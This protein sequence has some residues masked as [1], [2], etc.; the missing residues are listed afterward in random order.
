MTN[1]NQLLFDPPLTDDQPEKSVVAYK[2][3]NADLTCRDHQYAEGETYEHDGPAILCTSG[4]H[5]CLQPIHVL[6]Y[7]RP[8]TSVFHVVQLEGLAAEVDGDD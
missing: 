4:Y 2:A 8:G 6:R 5:A 7:Y 1:G 3:F